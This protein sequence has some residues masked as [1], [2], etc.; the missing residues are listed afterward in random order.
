[1]VPTNEHPDTPP[2]TRDPNSP[3]RQPYAPPVLEHL[4]E[5]KALT[6]QQSVPIGPGAFLSGFTGDASLG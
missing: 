5:W 1:M 2:L 6:L 4:G 3:A